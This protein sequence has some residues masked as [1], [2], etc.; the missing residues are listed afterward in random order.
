MRP[1][2]ILFLL[3]L[4]ALFYACGKHT[5]PVKD[6]ELYDTRAK[7]LSH[8]PAT[9]K[10]S[11]PSLILQDFTSGKVFEFETNPAFYNTYKD[12]QV[13][14]VR[15][16]NYILSNSS[17]V[18]MKAHNAA[19]LFFLLMLLTLMLACALIISYFFV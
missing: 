18:I 16:N 10:H 9:Y 2:F 12:G 8:Y 7:V 13:L 5:D 6:F 4:A 3:A 19:R 1:V 14:I 11:S 17:T 15:V